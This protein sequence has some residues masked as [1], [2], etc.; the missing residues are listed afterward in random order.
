MLLCTND[1]HVCTEQHRKYFLPIVHSEACS[2]L[3]SKTFVDAMSVT[4]TYDA[5]NVLIDLLAND[6]DW[7]LRVFGKSSAHNYNSVAFFLQLISCGILEIKS[8]KR[9]VVITLNRDNDDNY[10]YENC[11]S[12][13]GFEFRFKQR[14]STHSFSEFLPCSGFDDLKLVRKRKRYNRVT[15]DRQDHLQHEVGSDID[16]LN[17][18]QLR[19]DTFFTTSA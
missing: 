1:C 15:R 8:R 16:Q 6:K 7:L 12:W 10:R 18:T 4:L 9:E 3:K 11:L 2:F 17:M 19:L 14:G 5:P 13:E